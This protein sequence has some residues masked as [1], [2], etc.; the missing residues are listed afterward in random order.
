MQQ[1]FIKD[2][3]LMI[4]NSRPD[5]KPQNTCRDLKF[6]KHANKFCKCTI[7]NLS[8]VHIFSK[9]YAS[10]KDSEII[11][12]RLVKIQRMGYF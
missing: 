3:S 1:S 12:K 6:V 5:L 11:Y 4:K 10:S 8:P 2:L 9:M 7:K